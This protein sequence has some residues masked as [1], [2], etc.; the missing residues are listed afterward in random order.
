MSIVADRPQG[1]T[2]FKL[3]QLGRV[4]ARHYDD[5]L[6]EAG[7]KGTQ[8]S[9]LSHII[10]FGPLRAGELARRMRLDNSTL[11]RTLATL[12]RQGWIRRRAGEDA[13][14]RLIEATPAGRARREQAKQ[15]W[16]HAQQALNERLGTAEINQ[17]H[18]LLD[19]L[20]AALEDSS[21][22]ESGRT[23]PTG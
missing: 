22:T 5:Y 20:T 14:S 15:H 6:G 2:N 7:L 17:L 10:A 3:H 12:E 19:T 8:Y 16:K 11:T 4:V 1:C 9:L 23:E 18:A 21:D 13:R